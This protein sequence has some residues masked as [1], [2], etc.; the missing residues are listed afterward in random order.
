MTV[1]SIILFSLAGSP[2]SLA[3]R[4]WSPPPPPEQER[5]AGLDS[6]GRAGEL[7]YT[8][9]PLAHL[10]VSTLYILLEVEYSLN[11]RQ[12]ACAAPP[13]GPPSCSPWRWIAAARRCSGRPARPA[14]TGR[15]SRKSPGEGWLYLPT[16]SG[17]LSTT[18]KQRFVKCWDLL[19]KKTC[20]P[21]AR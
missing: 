10:A 15:S 18:R 8:L 2:A 12:W 11:C 19:I 21:T 6:R 5:G 1:V 20:T 9:Q 14:S 16:S 17:L 7:L 13:P 3:A 4:D